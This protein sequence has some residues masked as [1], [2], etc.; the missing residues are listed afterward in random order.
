MKDKKLQYAAILEE[1]IN[2]SK[3]DQEIKIEG[4]GIIKVYGKWD[5]EKIIKK[6]ME[7]EEVTG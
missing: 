1:R 2:N 7:Y 4:V 3:P 6:L 5:A